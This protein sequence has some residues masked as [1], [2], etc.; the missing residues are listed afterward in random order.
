MGRV[1][2]IPNRVN[3]KIQV[4][5]VSGRRFLAEGRTPAPGGPGSHKA[6][7][8]GYN[9]RQSYTRL[10]CTPQTAM[11]A[12]ALLV[13]L[14]AAAATSAGPA[15]PA[16]YSSRFSAVD[17]DKIL[18]NPRV[19]ANYV[20]CVTD[21]GPCTSEGKEIKRKSSRDNEQNY[22]ILCVALMVVG[23]VDP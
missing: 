18:A 13:L 5:A 2:L 1:A 8:S 6:A 10:Q 16:Q 11:H 9:K 22:R 19:L 15:T 20:K 14:V 3:S 23:V 17:V 4:Q 7:V 12:A 21:K